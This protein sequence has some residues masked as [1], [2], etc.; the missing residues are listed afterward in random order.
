MHLPDTGVRNAKKIEKNH[1]LRDMNG[2]HLLV[3][4]K[5]AESP[6]LLCSVLSRL[7]PWRFRG[8]L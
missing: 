5:S 6:H 2:L 4:A 3:C 7:A 8:A 1:V